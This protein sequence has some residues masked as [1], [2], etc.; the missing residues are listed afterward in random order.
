MRTI[1]FQMIS[2]F[3]CLISILSVSGCVVPGMGPYDKDLGYN[4]SFEIVDSELPVNWTISRYP[5][6]DGT[7]EAF[8]DTTDVVSGH[9]SLRIVIHEYDSS[10]RWEPFLFQVR[11]VEVGKT[12]TVSFW[13]KNQGCKV[14]LEIG[15]EGKYHMFGGQSE[16]ERLDYASHSRI[17]E[18]L[19]EVEL[20]DDEWRQF[21][22]KYTVPEADGTIR[23]EL[24]F[25]QKGTLWI[26]DVQ[27]ELVSNEAPAE[28]VTKD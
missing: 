14:L 8:V 1:L 17:S 9:R 16:E 12:Y 15:Y 19:G 24:K 3:V 4:G 25:L 2:R 27:I 18:I 23:F 11:D 7:I 6:R 21:Q 26:D 20:G 22:Y 13:L 5:V 10:S 28:G